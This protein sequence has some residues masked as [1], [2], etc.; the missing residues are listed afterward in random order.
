MLSVR[1]SGPAC[2]NAV[3]AHLLP[4][5]DWLRHYPRSWLRPD[6]T[7][8]LTTAAVVVPKAMAYAT[9]AGLPLEVGLY[10]ALVPMVVYAMLGTSRPLSVS[11]T[12]TIAILTGARAGPIAPG[13]DPAGLI[14]AAATLSVLVGI[15]LV[16]ASLLRL[17]FI[18]NFISDPVLTGFKA[19]IGL[20]IVVD[21]LP[22]LLGVH[23]D[24]VGFFRDL[25]TL[26]AATAGD[27][28]ADAAARRSDARRCCSGSSTS[29]RRVPAPLVAVAV[30]IA[31]SAAARPARRWAWRR[32][33]RSR[34]GCRRWCCRSSHL[35]HQLWPAA[36]GIALMSFTETIAAARAFGAAGEPRPEPNQELLAL[37]RRQRAWAACSAP[38]P[39]AAA[40]RRPR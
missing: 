21:Q 20:V 19:G 31:A 1:R 35:A 3:V 4:S 34:E 32:S 5:V 6:L 40:P 30:A 13:G 9:I 23:I 29:P 22:K 36:A 15:L 25:V 10:T 16:V 28:D 2:G 37:G 14:A 33:A 18:A 39:R 8:G 11:T 24:K 17:G 27:V 38:C 7:A 26:V 12:T